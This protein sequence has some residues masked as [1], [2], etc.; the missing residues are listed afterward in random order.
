MPPSRIDVTDTELAILDVLW[1]RQRATIRQIAD[2]LYPQR[3][4][5]AYA[6]VQKLLER[7]EAKGCVTRDR[8]SFSHVF[9]AAI[10]RQDLIDERLRELAQKLCQGSLTPLLMHL[11]GATKLSPR[12]RQALRKLIDDATR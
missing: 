1:E 5:A 11:A 3:T 9:Q 10:A 4:T 7:L 12:D 2:Q 6:T 8:S